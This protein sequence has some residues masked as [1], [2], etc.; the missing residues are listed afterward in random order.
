MPMRKFSALFDFSGFLDARYAVLA[1]G[2]FV[3]MLGQF[4][5]YYY[6]CECCDSLISRS[7]ADTSTGAYCNA[8]N[9]KSQAKDFLIPAMNAASIV[10]RILYILLCNSIYTGVS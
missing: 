1:V 2:A 10:G 5:P 7:S 4:V 9:P 6:I 3:T 8:A